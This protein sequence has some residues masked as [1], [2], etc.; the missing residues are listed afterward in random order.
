MFQGKDAEQVASE[1]LKQNITSSPSKATPVTK[2]MNLIYIIQLVVTKQE[3]AI[4]LAHS[5]YVQ[6]TYLNKTLKY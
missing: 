4:I 6:H 3:V 5:Q 2:N 1:V